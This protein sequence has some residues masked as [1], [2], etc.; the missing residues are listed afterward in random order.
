MNSSLLLFLVGGYFLLL[1]GIAWLT[2]R[3]SDED[4]FYIGNRKSKWYLVAWGMVGT[5]MTGITFIS[6]PGTVGNTAFS[7]FQVAIGYWLG[8]F[9]VVFVLL[10][11]Y[12]R[13]RLTSIYTFLEKRMGNNAH[14][15]GALFFMLSRLVGSTLRLYLVIKVLEVF[16][17]KDLNLSFGVSAFFI[18]VLIV[19]YTFK[20]GVKT[21]VW[22][23]SLQTTFMLL[24][25]VVS[26]WYLSKHVDMS[27]LQSWDAMASEGLVSIFDWEPRSPHF[28]LKELIGGAFITISMTGLDQEMMQKNISISRLKDARKNMLVMGTLQ[29]FVVFIFLFLGGLLIL[30]ALQNGI[31]VRGDD[32]FPTV[33]TA[34]GVPAFLPVVFTI[35][36]ISALFPSSDGALTA[37]T[38]SFCLDILNIKDRPWEEKRKKRTRW[39]VHL[40]FAL[41]FLLFVLSYQ[42]IDNG[43]LIVILLKMAGY[44]YGPLLGLFAFGILTKRT[45]RGRLPLKLS[46]L[47]MGLTLVLDLFNHPEWFISQFQW[48]GAGVNFLRSASDLIFQGYR[49]GY[50]LLVINAFLTFLLLLTCSRRENM[51][52]PS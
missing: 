45:V 47:S 30:F 24:A 41:L 3:K 22:T 38:S 21:I 48:E 23:D 9:V 25:L 40:S 19:L 1:L 29:M 20:G 27:M 42:W 35:G 43:S 4:S 51:K 13:L 46:L 39:L 18:L 33:V 44:T 34:P 26:V 8:Y 7:Y 6:V 52:I 32:L 14:K 15:T 2:S 10:P 11:L 12:Y 50:E 31:T 36:L 17:F 5:S 49:I 16:I 28:L 37:L